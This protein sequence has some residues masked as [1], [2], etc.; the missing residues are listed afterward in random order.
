MNVMRNLILAG[1][2]GLLAT[3][4]AADAR[5]RDREQDEAFRGTHDGRFV[6]L[7]VIES[8]IIP[9]MRG[10]DYLGPEL[11]AGMGRYRLKFIKGPQVVW[12]DVDARTGEIIARSGR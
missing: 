12:V 11:D 10:Y 4:P 7:R 1:L 9:Q 6:P 8:R 5:P 2:I 3:A